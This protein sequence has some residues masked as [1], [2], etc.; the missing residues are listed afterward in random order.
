MSVS[1]GPIHIFPYRIFLIFMWLLFVGNIF[2][3]NNG[4]LNLSHIKVKL[5]LQFFA[6]WLAYAFLSITWAADKVAAF[7][8][9]IFLFAGI[10]IV[11]FLVYYFRYLNHLKWLYWLWLLIFIALIP[12]GVW[13]VITGNHLSVSGLLNIDEDGFRFAP[14]TVFTNQNDFATHIA[15]TLPMVL[16]WIRYFPNLY[17]RA[18]GVLVFIAGLLLLI[19]TSSR[20]NYLGV[21]SGLIFWFIFLLKLKTKFNALTIAAFI[22]LLIVLVF[23]AQLSDYLAIV[24]RDMSSLSAI[25]SQTDDEGI[26]ERLNL[27][28]NALSFTIKSAGFGVGAGNVE[29]YMVNYPIY[30]VGETTNVHNWWLEILA[31]YGVVILGGYCILYIS[32]FLNLWRAYKRVSN[33]TER[34]ICEALLVGWLIFFMGSISSSSII[35]F[36]PQWIYLGFV[37]AFLNYSR[38]KDTVSATRYMS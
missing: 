27:I 13:E 32:L 26:N 15:L 16:V 9:I 23:P 37:L 7:K 12:I 2:L 24:D 19:L 33:C 3:I 8:N 4:R 25:G 17:S 36:A 28:K 20:A 34:M 11:F 1:V 21:L 18:S 31:N 10:S 14:T 5:Y 35:A 38:I 29:Y 22:Y 6:L 30:P